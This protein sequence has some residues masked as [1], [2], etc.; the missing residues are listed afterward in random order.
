[1]LS[2]M[3]ASSG[4]APIEFKEDSNVRPIAR[5]QVFSDR[6]VETIKMIKD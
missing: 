4:I 1:M 6:S 5:L 3:H 2:K